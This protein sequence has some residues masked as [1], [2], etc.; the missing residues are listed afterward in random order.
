M[1]KVALLDTERGAYRSVS[2]AI[3][4]GRVEIFDVRGTESLAKAYNA[5][6][7]NTQDFDRIVLDT[8]GTLATTLN[9]EML[10]RGG[11]RLWT[12]PSATLT[13]TQQQWGI[14]S[15]RFILA[16]RDFQ[17]LGLPFITA[18]H[19]GE[20][21]NPYEGTTIH[22]PDLN[23]MLLKELYGM[24]DF[25]FRIGK[26]P[27]KAAI[28]GQTYPPGTRVLRMIDDARFI[29]KGAEP[30]G[31][32]LLPNPTFGAIMEVWDKVCTLDPELKARAGSPRIVIY[33]PPGAGKTYLAC[34]E[35][36]L[37]NNKQTKKG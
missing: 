36:N 29:A 24:S 31:I 21:E 28:N 11:A 7:K 18:V 25:I 1:R 20:R 22:G 17:E 13:L 32:E 37:T 9:N 30:V 15:T 2:K 16:L 3:N 14:M 12:N 27:T 10:L 8:A 26:L 19:E 4:E 35:G 34:S 6:A 5:I 23:R 33:G